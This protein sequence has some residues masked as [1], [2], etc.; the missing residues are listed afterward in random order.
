MQQGSGRSTAVARRSGDASAT[1][2]IVS[3]L[4]SLLP[5]L[6][7]GMAT[8]LR[9]LSRSD[10]AR[11]VARQL[12]AGLAGRVLTEH[13]GRHP[14]TPAAVRVERSRSQRRRSAAEQVAVTVWFGQ[15]PALPAPHSAVTARRQALRV[16]AGVLSAA[17]VA[18]VTTAAA[19]MGTARE[20][21][22][23]GIGDRPRLG[24]PAE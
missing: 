12:D 14:L 11:Q 20:V 10:A 18:V 5:A 4:L 2:P 6:T 22:A 15:G 7:R 16:G 24:P 3:L 8:M 13:G 21:P 9:R 23:L 1:N 19:R 17:A